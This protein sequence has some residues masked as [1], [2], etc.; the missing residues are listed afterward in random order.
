[1]ISVRAY[2]IMQ[3]SQT[4]TDASPTSNNPFDPLEDLPPIDESILPPPEDVF[5]PST[6]VAMTSFVSVSGEAHELQGKHVP[7][8][9][10]RS[11]DTSLRAFARFIVEYL[12]LMTK[13][14]TSLLRNVNDRS[15]C[16]RSLE[17][18][19]VSLARM[20]VFRAEDGQ[21]LPH[22][23]TNWTTEELQRVNDALIEFVTHYRTRKGEPLMNVTL[24]TYLFALQRAF[25]S[26]WGFQ[27]NLLKGPVFA[28]PSTGLMTVVDNR[29]R[30]EQATGKCFQSHKILSE[31]DIRNLYK[32]K[33]PSKTSGLG[34]LT[35]L[36]FDVAFMTGFRPSELWNLSSEDVTLITHRIQV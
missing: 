32:S 5:H 16:K 4:S 35:R 15:V 27:L 30:K 24:R 1:M 18:Q 19:S 31:E 23:H 25:Q 33:H 22:G 28:N 34:F 7:D 17:D 9:T 29:M 11:D 13:E 10:K 26:V 3:N 20:Y 12:N 6:S 2:R 8:N 14:N 36:I 21:V